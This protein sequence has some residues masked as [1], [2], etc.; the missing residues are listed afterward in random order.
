M[1]EKN[2]ESFLLQIKLIYNSIFPEIK[3]IFTFKKTVSIILKS[4]C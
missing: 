3:V 2:I 4:K 1:N